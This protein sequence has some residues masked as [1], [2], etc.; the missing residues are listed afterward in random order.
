[1]HKPAQLS[2]YTCYMPKYQNALNEEL[3]ILVSNLLAFIIRWPVIIKVIIFYFWTSVKIE[4]VWQN[5]SIMSE[6]WINYIT[7]YHTRYIQPVNRILS[8]KIVP[9]ALGE[10]NPIPTRSLLGL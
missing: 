10:Q 1:M 3:L 6:G 2:D 9:F 7:Y 5:V 4:I 8:A